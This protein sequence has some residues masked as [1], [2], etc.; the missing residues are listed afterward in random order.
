MCFLKAFLLVFYFL[1][2][3]AVMSR[4]FFFFFWLPG[5]FVAAPGLSPDVARRGC[6]CLMQGPITAVTSL[7]ADHRFVRA[8]AA[9]ALGLRSSVVS[10]LRR[11]VACGIFHTGD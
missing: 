6:S 10:G 2:V 5:V 1:S 4:I 9:V 8:S 11:S 7:A 3:V